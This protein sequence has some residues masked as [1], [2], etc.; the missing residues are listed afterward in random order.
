MLRYS[1]V[2]SHVCLL[3][4]FILLFYA[5]ACVKTKKYILKRKQKT[6]DNKQGV[7]AGTAAVCSLLALA[8]SS[9]FIPDNAK[10]VGA[11][12]F[13]KT[14][15][16]IG[17]K[18]EFLLFFFSSMHQFQ[19]FKL[20]YLITSSYQTGHLKMPNDWQ[21]SVDAAGTGSG[22]PSRPLSVTAA[23]NHSSVFAA[24]CSKRT[25]IDRH[26]LLTTNVGRG[27]ET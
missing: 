21:L 24:V 13:G 10:T 20:N 19:W 18:P 1:D 5:C 16:I 22:D 6:K 23:L 2:Y 11:A 17:L 4:W 26:L 15:L 8:I 25:G 3:R 12:V 7:W 9:H 27:G 14:R